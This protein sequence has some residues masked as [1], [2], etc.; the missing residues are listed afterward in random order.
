MPK[1]VYLIRHG[2]TEGNAA[3]HFLGS[4]DLPLNPRGMG[5]VR[6]LAE[7]L[8]A[9]LFAPGAG[10][11][12]V[13]SPLLRA[14]QTAEAVAGCR[15]LAI[16]TDAD[17]REI[18]FGAWEGLTAGEIEVRSPGALDQWASPTGGTTFPEGESLGDFE[19]RVARVRDRILGQQAE[20]ALVFAHGGV[21]RALSCALLGL[22]RESFWLLDVQ[23]A[24][25]VRLDLFDGGAVLSGLWSVADWEGD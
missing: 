6:R 18:D 13:A 16:D 21:V 19:R 24:S 25:V 17:L 8:P 9:G 23:P 14:Q 15:G 20:A 7:L 3:G 10:T 1:R 2:E 22:G 4:T 11:W 12:C 5:Q